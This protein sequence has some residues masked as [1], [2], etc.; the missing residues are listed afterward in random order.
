M[1]AAPLILGSDPRRLSPATITMLENRQVIAVDQDPLGIQGTPIRQRGDGQ[2]WVKPLVGGSR[3]VAL[4]NRGPRT[5]RLTTSAHA[6]GL[7][8]VRGYRVENLWTHTSATTTGQ[9]SARVPPL[10]AVLYRVTNA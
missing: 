6:I 2:V 4:L 7:S 9:I 1:V 3:A 8:P 10:S 5:L